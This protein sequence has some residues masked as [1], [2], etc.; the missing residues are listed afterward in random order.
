MAQSSFLVDSPGFSRRAM[1]LLGVGLAALMIFYMLN[2]GSYLPLLGIVG[3]AGAYAVYKAA[4]LTRIDHR[5]LIVPLVVLAIFIKS[6]FL[7]GAL[8]AALH[9]GLT[10]LFCAPCIPIIWRT[11]IF[12]R[13]GFQLYSAYFA[14]ALV[15][16]TW[17]LAPKFSLLR[18]LDAT[19]VFCAIG[20]IV[21]E[22]H[23]PQDVTRLIERYLM[24]CGVFVILMGFAA[25]VLPHS[26]TWYAPELEPEEVLRFR[27]ILNNPNEVGVLML[28]TVA[29][30]L[31]FWKRLNPRYRKWFGLL[32][33]LAVGEC[34]LADSRTPF[35]ALGVGSALYLTWRYRLRGILM[36][37]AA[38]ALFVVALPLF[39]HNLSEYTGRG[40]VTTLTGRTEMWAYVVQEIKSRPLIGYGYECAGAIFQSKYFPIWYGPWDEGSQSSLHDGYLDHMIGVGVPATLFW[41]F[42]VLRPWWFA[43]RHKDDPWNL[44]PVVFLIVIPC[45]IHNISEASI[46]DFTGLI[47]L[48][49]GFSWAVGEHYKLLALEQV[50]TEHQ[51]AVDQMAP[52]VAVFQ[53]MKA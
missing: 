23:E 37:A 15:T 26:I 33:L 27:G 31:A 18:L 48:M 25:V 10:I 41:L 13:A 40:D 39:G 9:Y 32:A 12:R 20:T 30:T 49:F 1:P 4:A 34:A 24:G 7:E 42:I 14:W 36:M 29:P 21:F 22:L 5:W 51:R 17:S 47:G 50:E 45:L 8:R 16:V 35:I 38:A 43:M 52:A 2:G 11:G 46:G 28:A 6:F 19:L 53:S 3:V 44:K